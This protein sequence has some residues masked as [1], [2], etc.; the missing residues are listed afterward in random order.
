MN[1]TE[2]RERL[3]DLAADAPQGFTAPPRLLHRARRRVALVVASSVIIAV[4][5]V[6]G[7][8]AGEIGRAHV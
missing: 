6:F 8:I 7:G 1:E 4:A 2:I 3:V 5:I